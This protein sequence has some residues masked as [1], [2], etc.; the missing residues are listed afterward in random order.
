VSV[1]RQQGLI[2]AGAAAGAAF[3]VF[4]AIQRKHASVRATPDWGDPEQPAVGTGGQLQGMPV[5][6]SPD[7]VA[8]W[9]SV[10]PGTPRL[11]AGSRIMRTYAATLVDDPESMVR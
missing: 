9:F 6:P 7:P 1:N 2:A 8:S 10:R 11:N 5:P 3:A 4:I